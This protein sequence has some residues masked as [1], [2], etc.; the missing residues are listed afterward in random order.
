MN[1]FKTELFK[2][3][4]DNDSATPEVAIENLSDE[5]FQIFS[6][7]LDLCSYVYNLAYDYKLSKTEASKVLAKAAFI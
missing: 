6:N 4:F 5:S 7:L 2:I 1:A 3:S